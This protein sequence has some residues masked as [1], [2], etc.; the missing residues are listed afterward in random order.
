MS[1]VLCRSFHPLVIVPLCILSACLLFSCG[2]DRTV[3]SSP[4]GGEH[5]VPLPS[6]HPPAAVG[7]NRSTV[8]AEVISVEV[9]GDIDFSIT[10]KILDVREDA[11][12][13]SIAV[14]GNVYTLRPQFVYTETGTVSDDP[15]NVS[16]RSLVRAG[17]GESIRAV[18]FYENGKG[19][20]IS[21]LIR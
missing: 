8:I 2:S 6:D 19:W 12:Y 18:I 14:V 4:G 3:K 15:R 1:D 5:D 21:E 13:P 20:C 10:A 11:A 17:K 7:I 16:L 9:R